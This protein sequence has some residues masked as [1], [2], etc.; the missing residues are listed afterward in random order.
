MVIIKWLCCPYA[1]HVAFAFMVHKIIM[2]D[3]M[4]GMHVFINTNVIL[5]FDT[6][7]ISSS[8]ISSMSESSVA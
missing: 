8:D 6:F 1:C 3:I 4:N 7:H 2:N 5:I